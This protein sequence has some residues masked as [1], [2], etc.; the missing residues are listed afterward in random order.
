MQFLLENARAS[1]SFESRKATFFVCLC[2]SFAERDEFFVTVATQ[3][4]VES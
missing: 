3:K 2:L 4:N 1:L